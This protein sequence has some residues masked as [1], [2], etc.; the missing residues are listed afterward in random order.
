MTQPSMTSQPGPAPPP[1][2]TQLA[3]R[4]FQGTIPQEALDDLR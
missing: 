1:I 4:P 3:V 2:T